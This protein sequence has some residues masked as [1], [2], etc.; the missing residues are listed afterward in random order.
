MRISS[1]HSWSCRLLVEDCFLGILLHCPSCISQ[2]TRLMWEVG[3]SIRLGKLF[4]QLRNPSLCNF[5]QWLDSYESFFL[6][7]SPQFIQNFYHIFRILELCHLH[8]KRRARKFLSHHQVQ[9]KQACI[10]ISECAYLAWKSFAHP[11][12]V[13]EVEEPWHFRE[14]L[15]HFL[16]HY[17]VELGCKVIMGSFVPYWSGF[18]LSQVTLYRTS[19]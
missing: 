5:G 3:I 18:E 13:L 15:P 2:C 6:R 17:E 1:I 16:V 9:L 10:K 8:R 4:C 11:S 19:E 14:N 7:I 12:L